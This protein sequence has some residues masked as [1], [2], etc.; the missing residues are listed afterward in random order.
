MFNLVHNGGR[1]RTRLNERRPCNTDENCYTLVNEKKSVFS[2]TITKHRHIAL[3]A[4]LSA[5]LAS[6]QVPRVSTVEFSTET[7]GDESNWV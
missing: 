5:T 7:D 3:I 2:K 6:A 4:L 1:L